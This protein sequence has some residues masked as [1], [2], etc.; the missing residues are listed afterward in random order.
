MNFLKKT[1]KCVVFVIGFCLAA[2]VS[3]KATDGFAMTKI[4]SSLPHSAEEPLSPL[5]EHLRAAL[6]QPYIYLSKGAQ[7]YVFASADGNYVLKFFRHDHMRLPAWKRWIPLERIGKS[8][9]KR[10][11]KLMKDFA[12]YRLAYHEL[13]EETALLFLHLEKSHHHL[14]QVNL[15]DKLGIQ[16]AVPLDD[17]EFL[18]Q[19]RGELLYPAITR[20]MDQ[21]DPNAAKAII[22]SLI[23][24]LKQRSERGIFDKDPDLNTNFAVVD[25][26]RAI[27]IDIGR[28]R[29]DLVRRESR[30]E[31]LIRITDHFHQWL[32]IRYPDL[33]TMLKERLNAES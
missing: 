17:M 8:N 10:Q 21:G 7:T 16:H 22:D 31:E 29:R 9:A 18:L 20:A 6:D 24:V 33:D 23:D 32:M 27:Q 15:V 19:R 28:F 14:P 3:R 25:G 12:S 5:P 2:Y 26:K 11:A 30:K 13:P 4:T 1:G